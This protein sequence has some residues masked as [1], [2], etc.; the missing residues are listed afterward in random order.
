M[1]R[2]I[3]NDH[4][5]IAEHQFSMG[6]YT[7]FILEANRILENVM[8]AKLEDHVG[9]GNAKAE[10]AKRLLEELSPT[11]SLV[12]IPFSKLVIIYH[13]A[14]LFSSQTPDSLPFFTNETVN[15]IRK[16][17]NRCEHEGYQIEREE[18]DWVRSSMD[19]ILKE[20]DAESIVTLRRPIDTQQ[21]MENA[22]KARLK[23]YLME[24]AVDIRLALSD[25]VGVEFEKVYDYDPPKFYDIATTYS[26][27]GVYTT[28]EKIIVMVVIDTE[29]IHEDIFDAVL[30]D[31]V[32][33]VVSSLEVV[34][35]L[36]PDTIEV[37]VYDSY[38]AMRR[39][40]LSSYQIRKVG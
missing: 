26:V 28:E 23:K 9:T 3:L 19:L 12:R 17:R 8:K 11:G 29:N 35:D 5:R 7:Q 37:D 20:I 32:E 10:R 27:V 4:R 16:I 18:A 39:E 33:E 21:E 15:R 24:K 40:S 38:W 1:K 34:K 13:K 6:N 14:G 22:E 25:K 30:N 31:V 2:F 36:R